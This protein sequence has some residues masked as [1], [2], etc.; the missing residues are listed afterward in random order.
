MTA[1]PSP[2][3]ASWAATRFLALG[4]APPAAVLGLRVEDA[5]EEPPGD[6]LLAGELL[7]LRP[8]H[9]RR[10]WLLR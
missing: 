10:A 8:A 6:A 7:L 1:H 5:L 3:A 4:A 2:S 9:L